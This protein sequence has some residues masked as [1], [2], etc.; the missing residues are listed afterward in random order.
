ME[1]TTESGSTGFYTVAPRTLFHR[2]SQPET[3]MTD[4]NESE[5]QTPELAGTVF[6]VS[7]LVD[8]Q[9]GAIVSR[10]LIDEEAGTV[11]VFAFDESQRLSEH[12]SPHDAVLQVFDG[13]A[14]VTLDGDRHE[15]ADGE[16]IVMPA[17]VPHAVD[18]VTSFKMLLTMIR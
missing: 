17:D 5:S 12:T 8:Y 7:D 2:L 16:A 13:T 11:T 6:E 9:T 15:L 1:S 3:A 18:A 14:A 4:D 10:T